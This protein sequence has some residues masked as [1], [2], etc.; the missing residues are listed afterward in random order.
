MLSNDLEIVDKRYRVIDKLNY[1]AFGEIY[2]VERRL[3]KE[4]YALNRMV[5]NAAHHVSWVVPCAF[6]ACT[7]IVWS[8]YRGCVEERRC[9]MVQP[10]CTK[11]SQTHVLRSTEIIELDS[12]RLPANA[13]YRA[14][15]CPHR[16][17]DRSGPR[18]R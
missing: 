4:I 15:A 12:I 7:C 5:I 13:I 14:D 11:A 3:T 16:P 1:G 8:D 10:S 6:E 2:R 9:G 17:R 18:P